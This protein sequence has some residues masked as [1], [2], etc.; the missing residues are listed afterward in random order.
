[1]KKYMLFA[2]ALAALG[3]CADESFVGDESQREANE[4]AQ[5]AIV[6]G[7]GVNTVTRA[8][9]VDAA[10]DLNKNFVLFGS[11]G[12]SDRTTV[13]NNYQANYVANTANTT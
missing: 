3:S 13:F 1:M 9:G 12:S 8:N 6:F 2:V 7:T 4:N 11:K 5:G 10:N